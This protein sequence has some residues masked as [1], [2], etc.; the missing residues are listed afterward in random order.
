MSRAVRLGVL[1]VVLATSL[2]ALTSC[3]TALEL[4]V[5]GA[6]K[7][8]K[9]EDTGFMAQY[10]DLRKAEKAET[11][12]F[13]RLPDLFYFKEGLDLSGYSAVAIP[14]F[15]SLTTDP[16][17]LGGLQSRLNKT[18]RSDLADAV[19]SSFDGQPF[20]AVVRVNEKLDPKRPTL[21]ATVKADAV[22]FGNI[23]EARFTGGE[24]GDSPGLTGTEI[25]YKLVD[26]R[27]GEEVLKAIHRATTDTDKVAMGQ[28]RVLAALF[29]LV[30]TKSAL[31]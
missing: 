16:N 8:A 6:G 22:F 11:D 4:A 17:R 28:V 27:T 30:Q 23:K 21:P 15:T 13:G 10:S 9:A 5:V 31:R 18:M 3:M 26:L 25:E 14:D 2:L 20:R 12:S 19:A 1:A 29:K 24:G 7:D